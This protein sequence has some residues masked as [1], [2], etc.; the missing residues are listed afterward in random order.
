MNTEK[1]Q[2]FKPL[3]Q[4]SCGKGSHLTKQAIEY[5]GRRVGPLMLIEAGKKQ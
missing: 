4:A 1:Q 2:V 5:A 3:N